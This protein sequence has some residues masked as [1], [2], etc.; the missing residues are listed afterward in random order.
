MKNYIIALL[1]VVVLVLISFLYRYGTAPANDFPVIQDKR[2][3]RVEVPVS[4]YVFFSKKDCTSCFEVIEILNDLPS[5]FVVTGLVPEEE[6]KDETG[7]RNKTGATFPLKSD[8][9]FRKYRPWYTPT[10]IGVSPKGIILF[11]IP[12]VPGEKEYIEKFLDSLYSRIYPIF[13]EEKLKEEKK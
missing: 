13:L 9:S 12:G 5:Q 7:L 2:N 4:L 8:K 10:I 11:K 6:L 3:S 1:L